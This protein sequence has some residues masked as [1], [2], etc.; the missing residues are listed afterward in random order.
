MGCFRIRSVSIKIIKM[1]LLIVFVL[2]MFSVFRP[3]ASSVPT[4]R[5]T[6]Q[7]KYSTVSQPGHTRNWPGKIALSGQTPGLLTRSS[8][9]M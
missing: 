5:I 4:V 8:L 6:K 1:F 3:R 9:S 7:S 2:I